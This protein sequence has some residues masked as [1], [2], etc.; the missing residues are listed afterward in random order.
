MSEPE[1]AELV[2]RVRSADADALQRLIVDYHAALRRA[3]AQA[4][5]PELQPHL[6]PE[7]VLQQAYIAAFRHAPRIPFDGPGHFYAWLEQV[8]LNQLKD[9]QRSLRR[10]K[11]DVGRHVANGPGRSTAGSFQGVIQRLAGGQ[12]TPSRHVAR[13]EAAAAVLTCLA[14]LTDDQRRVVRWRVLEDVPVAEIARRLSKSEQA[15]YAVLS[16]GL[17]ALRGMLGPLTDWLSR[18]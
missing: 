6:A 5:P 12:S 18:L 1:R 4:L 8:A 11:R 17:R 13:Q 2:I 15:V 16:R 14:R 3:V 10:R 7:D 9:A